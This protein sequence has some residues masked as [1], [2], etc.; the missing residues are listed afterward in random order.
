[1]KAVEIARQLLDVLDIE[2]IAQKTG[3]SI[4][5]IAPLAMD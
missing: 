1:L 5:E 2:T 4:D 3:L